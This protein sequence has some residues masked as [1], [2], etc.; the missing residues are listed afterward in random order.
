MGRDEIEAIRAVAALRLPLTLTC[1]ARAKE[2]DIEAAAACGT[3]GIHISFPVSG[4][5]LGGGG[6]Q[7]ER[8]ILDAESI[9][10]KA[11]PLFDRISIGCLD[12]TRADP[13]LI[14][15]LARSVPA[16]GVDR[17]RI[18]D[19]VGVGDPFSVRD[20]VAGLV[21]AVPALVF[22]FHGH[23]DFG[24]ATANSIAAVEGG[25]RAVSVTVNGLGERA[26]NA[27]LEEVAAALELRRGV[28][29][30]IDLSKLTSLCRRV[31]VLAGRPLPETK[32]IVGARI[33]TH[34]SGMHVAGLIDDP[35]SF[36]A[37]LPE[38]VGAEGP[39]FVAGKH[40]GS[41]ALRYLLAERGI[42]TDDESVEELLQLVRR[43]AEKRKRELTGDELEELYRR[44]NER[45]R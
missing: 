9:V 23:D 24:M 28:Q 38:R 8:L 25:A 7:A 26:G 27:P 10:A 15:G 16:L 29:T 30:G 6:G 34:E 31:A 5:R 12:A 3:P 36:Q 21:A 1:W 35:R 42:T 11:R 20:L 43:T 13:E 39:V 37:F 33:F 4:A 22:E 19:T 2:A 18:A 40:S 32:P 14:T 45:H 17:V 41:R 44:V